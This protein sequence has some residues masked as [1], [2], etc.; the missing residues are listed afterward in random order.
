MRFPPEFLEE[1]KSRISIEEIIGRYCDLKAAG[2]RSKCLCPF[3]SERTP[4]FCVF[5][6]TQSYY[7]FGCGAGGDA[8]KFTMEIERLSYGE[9]V[10][11]L[12]ERVGLQTP[13]EVQDDSATKLKRRCYAAN[14]EAALFYNHYLRSP[15]GKVGKDYFLDRKL[16]ENTINHFGLGYAPDSWDSLVKH[17]KSKGYNE[18]ELVAFGLALKS[19]SGRAID[20]F[21]NRVMFPVIDIRGRVIGFTGRII[22]TDGN[23]KRKYVNTADTIVY[24]KKKDLYGLNFAKNVKGRKLILVEGNMDVIAMHQAG[25]ENTIA[26]MGT[27]FGQDQIRLLRQYCDELYL[28]FDSDSAGAEA[29]SRALKALASTP[30]KIRVVKMTGGK[31]AD[32]ILRT[33]GAQYMS[34]L[35]E[36]ATNNTEFELAQI[37]SGYNLDTDDG[38]LGYLNDAVG[39]IAGLRNAVE[40]D[41]YISRLAEETNVRKAAIEQQ[42]KKHRNYKQK[43]ESGRVFEQAVSFVTGNSSASPNPEM[44]KYPNAVRAEETIL[45]MLLK[46]PDFLQKLG[47]NLS[48]DIFITELNKRFFADL[49]GRILSDRSIDISQ[50]S[51]MEDDGDVSY[52]AYLYAKSSDLECSI[53][54]CDECIARLLSEK[55]NMVQVDAST[56]SDEEFLAVFRKTGEKKANGGQ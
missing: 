46:A 43:E 10:R 21:R 27:A 7:C 28:C 47:K 2:P 19:K 38:R 24:K 45:A 33:K 35:I 14:R 53:S 26:G 41:L 54:E 22:T 36:K 9:A 39:L 16:T 12:A 44:K 15:Q 40:A 13:D 56:M 11:S 52:I 17:M 31:D 23:D 6:D 4:S 5:S 32:E 3:H 55:A 42:V 48:Q 51:S 49:S 20:V 18:D 34:R 1:L 8:I 25:F 50:F 37:R 29:T 30:I